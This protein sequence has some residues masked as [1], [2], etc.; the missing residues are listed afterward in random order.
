ML[1][2]PALL[3]AISPIEQYDSRYKH[4]YILIHPARPKS[5]SI[6]NSCV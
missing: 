3:S 4:C 2:A 1:A 6:L 5:V